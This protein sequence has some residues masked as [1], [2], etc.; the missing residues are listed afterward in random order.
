MMQDLL[1]RYISRTKGEKYEL[2]KSIPSSYLS[3]L[4][5]TR[6]MMK[7]RGMLCG[8]QSD[9]IPFIGKNVTIKAGYK[10]RCGSGITIGNGTYIDALSSNG[11][12]LGNNV[13]MGFNVRIECTGNLRYLGVGM[14]VGNNVG[15]GADTFFGC[16]G[17]I[18]IGDDCIFGNMVS[19]HAENHIFSDPDLAIRLQ[20]VSR[21][22][23]I[24][25]K[26]CWIGAKATI[27]DGAV[28]GDGCI[29]AAG[30]VV[31][32]GTYEENGIY[33]GVPAK[34]LKKR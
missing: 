6:V 26:N 20:G 25:G 14:Q 5:F 12:Q 1:N 9:G 13:S 27:L 11:V 21:K 30:A 3:T 4:L 33:G 32:A 34:L 19:C 28:I 18:R 17:G 2:D 31:N 10:F 15:L 22:G 8:L 24:I 23:I 16:A 7:V 29:I